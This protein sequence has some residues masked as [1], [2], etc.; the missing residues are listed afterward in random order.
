GRAD[1][2]ARQHR[3]TD[4][5]R[6]EDAPQGGIR[7]PPAHDQPDRRLIAPHQLRSRL[8]IAGAHAEDEV[9]KRKV[10]RHDGAPSGIR[11]LVFLYRGFSAE[12][13][14]IPPFAKRRFFLQVVFGPARN[15]DLVT[16]AAKEGCETHRTNGF[17]PLP[18]GKRRDHP[19]LGL[20]KYL[21]LTA[22]V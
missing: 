4:V 18:E 5:R 22:C 21:S 16:E 15:L 7:E 8:V 3:L 20:R 9:P 10:H 1:K 6:V 11:P 2:E 13:N 19:H 14:E 17:Y 12:D